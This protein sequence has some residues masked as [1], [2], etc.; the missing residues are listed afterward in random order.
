MTEREKLIT[1]ASWVSIVGNA[2]LS[3]SKI[4]VGLVGNSL[5]VLGDG[6][7]SA[8]D[9]VI[10]A[11]M[12]I[13]ARIMRKPPSRKYVYGYEKAESIATK[14]LSLVIFYVGVQMLINSV[15]SLF[16]DEVHKMPSMLAVWVTIFSILGKLALAGYQYRS[17]K[18]AES[19]MLMANAVNMRDD[20]LISCGVLAGLVFTFILKMPI[21]DSVAGFLISFFILRSAIRIFI[22]SNIELMDGVADPDIYDHIFAAVADVPEAGRPHR[23]RS[24]QIGGQYLI[25]LDIEVDGN[26][27]VSEAHAIAQRVEDCICR[28]VERVYDIVV[29]VEPAGY[30]HVNEPFGIEPDMDAGK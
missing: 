5:A 17:G 25:V 2:V 4:V 23:V 18:R 3:V 27:T 12:V 10:S 20:V 7:D 13:T 16:S 1:R 19:Q 15:H 14:V 6:I 26:M 30:P 24:R 9:V 22:R 11:V 8:A 28:R 21:L 29:H